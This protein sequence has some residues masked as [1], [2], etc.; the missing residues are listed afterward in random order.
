MQ[1]VRAS[2]NSLELCWAATPTASHYIL[3]VQKIPTPPSTPTP[4]Q[5]VVQA[6]P[7]GIEDAT[8][9]IAVGQIRKQIQARKP[10]ITTVVSPAL[11]NVTP[12]A[13][14]SAQQIITQGGNM[15]LSPQTAVKI[16]IFHDFPRFNAFSYRSAAEH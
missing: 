6:L 15:I 4:P 14:A 1:L 16:Y 7:Q 8:S 9:P 11:N 5:P 3:E 12:I 10:S 2:T 13:A